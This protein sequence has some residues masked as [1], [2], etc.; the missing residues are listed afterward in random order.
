MSDGTNTQTRGT[1][2]SADANPVSLTT[3]EYDRMAVDWTVVD[4]LWGG[5]DAMRKSG[6]R[7]LPQMPDEPETAYSARLLQSVLTNVYKDTIEKLVSKPLK[8]PVT[9][10]DDVPEKIQAYRG[11]IDGQGTDLD[12]FTKQL[13]EAALN[14]GLTHML[15]DYPQTETDTTVLEERQGEIRPYAVHYIAPQ[16]IGWKSE[17]VNGRRKLTQ[18][19]IAEESFEDVSEFQQVLVR[20]IRV[21]EPGFY[22]TYELVEVGNG[23]SDWVLTDSHVVTANGQVL[24][25]I[26][27]VTIYSNKINFMV[28][29]PAMMDVAHLNVTHWQSD[30]DQRNILHIARVPIL[31]GSG[32][33]EEDSVIKI[34]IGSTTF[35]KGQISSDLKYV[36]HSGKGIEAG[37]RDLES[38]VQR[39][40]TLGLNMLVR[41]NVSGNSSGTATARSLDQSEADSPLS[42]FARELENGLE[43]AL[44]FFGVFMALGPDDGGSVELFKDFSLTL[45][46]T[47]DI[48]ELGQMRAR[49]DLSQ[50][51]YWQELK[52]RN[53]LADDFD[54]ET[55]IDLLDLES[56]GGDRPGITEQE[57]EQGNAVGDVT[58][59][60]DG[61]THTLQA[62][63]FTN[64]VEGHRHTWETTGGETGEAAGHVHPLGEATTDEDGNV[65]VTENEDD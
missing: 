2:S 29:K 16:V 39:M 12:V 47:D 5:T 44:D 63:G 37:E 52:R 61:H 40:A 60:A 34:S 14:H 13:G 15:V 26:P 7:F 36:E 43:Q 51:T 48:K 25:F 54:P 1:A 11:N 35:V 56:P 58:G 42:M 50:P 21:L 31:F 22:R 59:D 53:L 4:T 27:W 41:K 33:G 64:I 10:R 20:R 28:A 38:L 49:G 55:E 62:N 24:D 17:V 32:L 46:D 3:A 6:K 30:S 57:L 18:V 19:R 9:L 65:N 23:Q 45:R 8:Q